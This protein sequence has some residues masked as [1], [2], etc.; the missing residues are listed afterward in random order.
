[1]IYKNF[2]NT[3]SFAFSLTIF[4]ALL[5]VNPLQTLAA[6]GGLDPTFSGNGKLATDFGGLAD[7]ANAVAVQP[8]GKIVVVGKS[9]NSTMAMARYNA[10]GMLDTT[11]SGDKPVPN[12]F[13]P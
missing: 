6:G 5:S 12:A 2:R 9:G 7:Q 1:M 11:F 8:N 4:A 13:V 10:D 3:F